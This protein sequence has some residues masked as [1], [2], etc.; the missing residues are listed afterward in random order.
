MV[1]TL[2]YRAGQAYVAAGFS[3][4]PSRPRAGTPPR[5]Y[6]PA[7]DTT[8]P[9]SLPTF[10]SPHHPSPNSPPV[11]LRRRTS[12]PSR[13]QDGSKPVLEK[14]EFA[15]VDADR[16][17]RELGESETGRKVF[18]HDACQL[19]LSL[20]KNADV[21]DAATQLVLQATVLTWGAFEVLS[22]EIFRSYLNLVPRASTKLLADSDVRK[23]FDL[24][25]ISIEK[26]AEFN[27]DLSSKLGDML[28]EVNDLADF[29]GI[30]SAFFALFPMDSRLHSALNERALWLLFQ[31]RNVIVHRRGIVDRQYVEASG[32][33]LPIGSRLM[34]RPVELERYLELVTIAAQALVSIGLLA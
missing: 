28:I 20:A 4:A 19:L 23:R 9:F 24:S 18:N 1:P 14:D 30:K 17:I 27:F 11:V 3:L 26:V 21:A 31:R 25:R 7:F 32:N 12:R 16:R 5:R 2:A 29:S 34:V 10:S 22:R 8:R 13:Q 6:T 15:R 33:E